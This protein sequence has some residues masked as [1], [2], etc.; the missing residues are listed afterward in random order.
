MKALSL[1]QPWA[2]AITDNSKRV[3]NRVWS[4]R[5]RGPVLLHAAKG[6]TRDEYRSAVVWMVS[7]GL[8][9]SPLYEFGAMEEI[10]LRVAGVDP[11]PLPLVPPLSDMRRGG[12][13]GRARIV[14]V[15]EPSAD[16]TPRAPWHMPDQWGFVL[17]DVEP[18]PFRSMVGMLGFFAVPEATP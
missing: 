9:R 2:W 14:D 12:I 18:L 11:Q 10:A 13:V 3:E 5:F 1:R 8:A 4:T 6:C 15:L 7:R 17:E 16:G